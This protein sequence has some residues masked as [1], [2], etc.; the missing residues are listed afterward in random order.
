V[1]LGELQKA[2][3]EF[4]E[5]GV[6]VV[7]V[8]VDT[9]EVSLPWAQQKNFTFP[10]VSDPELDVI[11]KWGLENTDVGNLSLHA[12]FI[13]DEAGKIFYRKVARRRPYSP[14]FLD[15]IDYHDAR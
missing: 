1:Q 4:D 13:L 2:L 15:A 7:V 3:P 14:E 9:P 12:V 5:R 11:G 8:S 6:T 10:M